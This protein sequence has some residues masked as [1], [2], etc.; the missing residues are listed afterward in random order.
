MAIRHDSRILIVGSGVFGISTALWLARSGYQDI[1]VFDMQ[2]TYSSGYDPYAG[3]DSASADL[4]KIIRFSYGDEIEYQRLAFEAA[5]LWEEWNTEI[6]TA[7]EDDLPDVLRRGVRKLW[8]NCGYLRMSETAQ[9]DEFELTTLEN[10]RREG[11][12]ETQF[13]VD[14]ESGSYMHTYGLILS[15]CLT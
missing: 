6:A 3:I 2:D 13:M 1:T 15:K 4:N 8:W 12:R 9:Y 14:D 7:D 11:I 10:M 5:K